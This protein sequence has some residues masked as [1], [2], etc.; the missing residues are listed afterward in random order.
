MRKPLAGCVEISTQGLST[1]L[2]CGIQS[3]Y[4]G[5]LF[6][7]VREDLRKRRLSQEVTINQGVRQSCSLSL[8]LF[9]MYTD[10]ILQIWMNFCPAGIQISDK[11]SHSTL[12]MCIRDS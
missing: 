3:L 9:N 10:E 6:I 4:A 1:S 12:Q 7:Y 11:G 8:S 2:I 5:Q